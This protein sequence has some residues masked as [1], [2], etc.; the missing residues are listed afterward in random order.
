MKLRS[1]FF[2]LEQ[3]ICSFL[4]LDIVLKR[5]T[6]PDFFFTTSEAGS[7]FRFQISSIIF[8]V[9]KVKLLTS[10]AA[11][12]EKIMHE[13][14]TNIEYPLR[15]TRVMSKT[16]AG[17]GNVLIED[18]LFHGLIPNRVIIGIVDN[19]A[20]NGVKNK[21]PFTFKHKKI[22]E[23]GLSVN[24]VA[25]P[26]NSVTMDFE[27]KNYVKIYH[28]MLD[29]M[30][31]VS[32]IANSNAIDITYDE[33]GAG[34]TLFNFDL[35]PDQYGNMNQHL[36]NQ[37]ANVQLKIKFAEGKATEAITLIIYYELFSRLV[38][39]DTR[40]VQLFEKQ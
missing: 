11:S 24:G 14:G 7:D 35:S 8:H 15:D 19:D 10:V 2:L 12:I 27:D 40:R 1:P 25:T 26:Y 23:I 38:V 16:Y 17:Y 13:H 33:F 22:T 39:D 32:D 6:N 18:N 30:H 4:N 9:R 5:T 3:Y 29:S 21:N 34:Y 20:F 37:P 31:G 36:F 28:L